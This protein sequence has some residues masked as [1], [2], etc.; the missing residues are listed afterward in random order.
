MPEAQA[1]VVYLRRERGEIECHSKL[2]RRCAHRNSL[3]PETVRCVLVH[4]HQLKHLEECRAIGT[5]RTVYAFKGRC[6]SHQGLESH[7]RYNST[8]ECTV[9]FDMDVTVGS[10]GWGWHYLMLW[11]LLIVALAWCWNW[12]FYRHQ[13]QRRLFV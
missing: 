4:F 2:P 13:W 6:E 10:L 7:D 9:T 1:R 5:G 12:A 8:P 11:G 3:W